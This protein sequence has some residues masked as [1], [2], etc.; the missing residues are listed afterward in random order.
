[1]NQNNSYA[2]K[3]TEHASKRCQQ[4]GIPFDVLP[5]IDQ[6]GTS[7]QRPGGAIEYSLK[8]KDSVKLINNLKYLIRIIEKSTGKVILLGGD[9][10]E[11]ITVYHNKNK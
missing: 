9:G 8:K 3:L 1:M 5:I 4:R 11:I 2:L 6:Y 7:N 10:G